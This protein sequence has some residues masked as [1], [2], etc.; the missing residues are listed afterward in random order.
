MRLLSLH[1]VRY[2][3]IRDADIELG[4]LDLFIGANA[5][6]KSTILDALRFLQEGVQARDFR[7]PVYSRGGIIHLAWKG[8]GGPGYPPRCPHRK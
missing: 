2:R 7:T 1:A 3:S 4:G 8:R 5:S 6:G